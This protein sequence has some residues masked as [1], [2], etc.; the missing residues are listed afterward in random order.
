MNLDTSDN[1]RDRLWQE[2]EHEAQ[3]EAHDGDGRALRVIAR[4]RAKIEP[5]RAPAVHEDNGA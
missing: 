5:R 4:L 1:P 3:Q 2:L